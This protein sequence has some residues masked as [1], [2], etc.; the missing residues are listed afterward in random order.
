MEPVA[1]MTVRSALKAAA[2]CETD[3]DV[4]V[5]VHVVDHDLE[6]DVADM[7]RDLLPESGDPASAPCIEGSRIVDVNSL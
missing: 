4:L 6:D 1:K 5:R 7:A 3:L 2:R